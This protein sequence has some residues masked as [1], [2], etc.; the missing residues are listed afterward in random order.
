MIHI[1]K[2][3]DLMKVY[4]EGDNNVKTALRH[5]IAR[6]V[7]PYE[8][9]KEYLEFFLNVLGFE[10]DALLKHKF[11]D[12]RRSSRYVEL[13]FAIVCRAHSEK[14][15]GKEVRANIV[16]FLKRKQYVE[17][18]FLSKFASHFG[19]IN[20]RVNIQATAT[21]LM[22]MGCMEIS[23]KYWWD[24][25]SKRNDEK[26]VSSPK[27]SLVDSFN[28]EIFSKIEKDSYLKRVSEKVCV[29]TALFG[30]YDALPP[31]LEGSYKVDY[32]CFTDR[33]RSSPGW[34][35][36]IVEPTEENPILENR[37]YKLLPHKHLN[38]YD[39][40]LYVDSNIFIVAD[41]AKVISSC[42]NYPFAGWVHPERSDV[43]DEIASIISSYRHEPGKMLEQ[44]IFFKE[45]QLPRNSGMIEACF[46]WRDHRHQK[47][48]ELMESWWNF[49]R[50]NGNRDQPA[51]TYFMA[52]KDL[53]PRVFRCEFGTTR[54]ND[55]YVKLPHVG[56]PLAAEFGIENTIVEK[57]HIKKV[58]FLYR[59][60]QKQVASTFMRGYQLS[61]MLNEKL[62]GVE[63][64]YLNETSIS[65][66][67]NTL[68]FVTK[69][70]L[71][72]AK[73]EEL[74]LLRSKGNRIA[75]DFVDD[76][77]NL[78]LVE[79]CDV[80]I[81]S[82]IKQLLF[83]KTKFP[84]K[85]SHMITHHTDPDIPR[86]PHKSDKPAIG[87]FG[88]LIN[89][90]WKDELSGKVDFVL[91]NTK[92]RTR[93]WIERLSGFNCHYAVRNKRDI[94][95]FKP[96]L[97]GFTAAHCNSAILVPKTEGDARHYLTS[98]YPYLCETDDFENVL[99]TIDRFMTEFGS[100]EHRF[101]M[102]IM[103]SIRYRSSID[104][105]ANEFRSLLTIL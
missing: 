22:H 40:S 5:S 75:F 41:I 21:C 78:E 8:F 4:H 86:L 7:E 71:K 60:N 51:L 6:A 85:L 27:I 87:Y 105:I 56:N 30:D 3:A 2:I 62:S 64:L 57:S 104:Y 47:V 81:A 14:L 90:K 48:G 1:Q 29:Y 13:L 70:F 17:A 100:S 32:I 73:V 94:D 18:L 28:D 89:A 97:K 98:D 43:Y 77:P 74:E 95:G 69:G 53:R 31:V 103:K 58:V 24:Y 61:S 11:A 36:I 101:A 38:D 52:K 44:F 80:L 12:L 16:D 26:F 50:V 33:P 34:H 59:E 19:L 49:V 45:N 10:Q 88:E 92:T 23:I 68:V 67:H 91:T 46:L 37:K 55:F 35:F 54:L 84:N 25:F 20:Q 65:E 39:C 66:I 9:N 96:F 15:S 93:E 99:V 83:Y 102:D 63:T 82:S 79:L 42:I 76:P 72:Q